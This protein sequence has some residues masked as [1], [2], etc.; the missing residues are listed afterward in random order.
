MPLSFDIGAQ[1]NAPVPPAQPAQ[2]VSVASRPTGTTASDQ[3][4]ADQVGAVV[5]GGTFDGLALSYNGTTRAV[6]GTNTDKGSVAV[7][8]HEAASDPHP[9][10]TTDAEVAA[11]IAAH[12]AASDPHPQYVRQSSGEVSESLDFTG[13]V[14]FR[15]SL[16]TYKV[17]PVHFMSP[18][19]VDTDKTALRLTPDDKSTAPAGQT[20]ELVITSRKPSGAGDHDWVLGLARDPGYTSGRLLIEEPVLRQADAQERFTMAPGAVFSLSRLD[21]WDAASAATFGYAGPL[22]MPG[23][24]GQLHYSDSHLNFYS[25][26][27]GEW[28]RVPHFPKPVSLSPGDV[29]TWDGTEW[30]VAPG[31]GGGGGTSDHGALLGLADDDHPQYHNDSRGDARYLRLTGG[32][33]TGNL[34]AP[35]TIVGPSAAAFSYPFVLTA[36]DSSAFGLM[37]RHS[38]DSA[39]PGFVM[40]KTRGATASDFTT[41]TPSG[42]D[43]GNFYFHGSDGVSNRLGATLTCR[44]SSTW[45]PTNRHSGF[46]F[47]PV[48]SGGTFP[49]TVLDVDG[50]YVDVRKELRLVGSPGSSGQVM[51]SNGAGTAPSWA[52]PGD[53][54]TYVVMGSDEVWTNVSS[55]TPCSTL[56][57]LAGEAGT[58]LIEW[59]VMYR[60]NNL[61]SL[62]R[63]TLYRPTTTVDMSVR[64]TAILGTNS[65]STIWHSMTSSAAYTP[66]GTAPS[67]E[68]MLLTGEGMVITAGAMSGSGIRFAGGPE[69]AGS[70]VTITAGSLLRWRKIA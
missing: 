57:F 41:A 5:T 43:L 25:P 9:Q 49:I 51:R 3:G 35:A 44:A 37:Q 59:R 61:N 18:G 19:F 34:L 63:F 14:S 21:P 65:A 8:A 36:P 26:D 11:E 46:K 67:L 56:G 2:G 17:G 40:L 1:S 30:V 13:L 4:V 39:G 70:N 62:P 6:S 69:L 52:T 32:T 68:S 55:Y 10:Y 42:D 15:G 53:G 22:P 27:S 20:T 48:P 24:S 58:F 7:A 54:W 66:A 28:R 38:A 23:L 47:A 50:D 31:G 33:L 64:L 29:P 45:S 60:T 12:E 16:T